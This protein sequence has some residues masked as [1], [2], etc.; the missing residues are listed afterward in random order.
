V[1]E[2]TLEELPAR[3][4]THFEDLFATDAEARE[5]AAANVRELTPA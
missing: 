2:R 1:I 5:R 4:V 3:P